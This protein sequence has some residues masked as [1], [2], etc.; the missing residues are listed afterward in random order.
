VQGSGHGRVTVRFETRSTG[1]GQARTLAADDPDLTPAD[2]LAS[3]DLSI[4]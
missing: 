4:P 2:P 1:P 3:L